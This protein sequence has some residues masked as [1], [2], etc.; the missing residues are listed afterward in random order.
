VNVK[1]SRLADLAVNGTTIL[2]W[3][4]KKWPVRIWTGFIW[5]RIGF[6]G[7]LL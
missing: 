1:K 5:L 2:K 3:I 4:L 6:Y 7:K